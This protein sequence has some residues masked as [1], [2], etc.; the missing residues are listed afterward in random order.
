MR[1]YF[2]K[3]FINFKKEK[4]FEII[5]IK[6]LILNIYFLN[7]KKFIFKKKRKLFCIESGK[8]RSVNNFFL[9]YRMDLKN[10]FNN[11]F[12]NGLKKIS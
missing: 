8:M 12:I 1:S 6:F 2:F 9:L 11:G 7:Q 10:H 4:F 5:K 3:Y